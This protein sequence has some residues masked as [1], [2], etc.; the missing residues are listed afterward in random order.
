MQ[1]TSLILAY[2]AYTD[3][4]MSISNFNERVPH[5]SKLQR[6]EQFSKC[7]C[8][9][10]D[11]F[12]ISVLDVWGSQTVNTEELCFSSSSHIVVYIHGYCHSELTSLFFSIYS[13]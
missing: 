2:D 12:L 3:F 6:C 10:L 4:Y 8:G 13:L 5:L 9:Q 11:V 1:S 7:S